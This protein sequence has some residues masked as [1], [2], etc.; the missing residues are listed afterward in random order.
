MAWDT[1]CMV[2]VGARE[3][4]MAMAANRL[5]ELQGGAAV[6][7]DGRCLAE[8]SAPIGGIYS[9]APMPEIAADLERLERALRAL[10]CR[11]EDPLLAADVL[12]TAAIP[13]FR[14]TQ[15][16]YVRVRDGALLGVL[17]D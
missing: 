11:L 1:Q 8:F 4:D 10:G 7:A 9:Q 14:I 16:G 6:V 17:A 2:V 12:T 15:R 5:G 13:H 3:A